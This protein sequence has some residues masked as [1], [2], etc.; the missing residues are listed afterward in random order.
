MVAKPIYPRWILILQIVAMLVMVACWGVEYYYPPL[1]D[2]A[3]KVEKIT[4]PLFLLLMGHQW[5]FNMAWKR[6][7]SN[8]F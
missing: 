3:D 8:K 7:R 6:F 5:G 1:A 2:V 4:W